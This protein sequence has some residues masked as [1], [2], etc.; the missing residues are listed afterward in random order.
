MFFPLSLNGVN[1]IIGVNETD[2][3]RQRRLVAH[4]FTEKTL[5][6]QKLILQFYVD[7]LVQ[8]MHEHIQ[9]KARG[10]VDMMR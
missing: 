7:L 6:Q 8:R 9:E 1:S 4:A 2:H 10:K 5:K 3:A